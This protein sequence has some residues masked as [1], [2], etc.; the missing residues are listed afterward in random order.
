MADLGRWLKG[1]YAAPVIDQRGI[2][3]LQVGDF[4][5]DDS[6]SEDEP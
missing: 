2:D 3:N 4:A 1:D 5:I 6:G